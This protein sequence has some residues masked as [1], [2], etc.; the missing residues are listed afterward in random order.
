[1]DSLEVSPRMPL[2]GGGGSEG[3]DIG[4][5]PLC[6]N[7]RPP[8]PAQRTAVPPRTHAPPDRQLPES[9]A[10]DSTQAIR[11]APHEGGASPVRGIPSPD[12][13]SSPPRSDE[14]RADENRGKDL[15]PRPGS[16]RNATLRNPI[17]GLPYARHAEGDTVPPPQGVSAAARA[18]GRCPCA[19]RWQ[20][21]PPRSHG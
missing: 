4:D 3:R 20:R 14:I 7:G 13:V 9:W 18:P 17:N 2:R 19:V 12:T 6:P 8:R 16:I 15:P 11:A 21:T 1:M 5:E 10:F